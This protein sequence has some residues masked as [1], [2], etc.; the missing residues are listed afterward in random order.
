MK[1]TTKKPRENIANLA[2]ILGYQVLKFDPAGESNLVR[3]LLGRNYPRFHLYLKTGANDLVF[4]L[5]LDQ[6][7]PSYGR[8]T[9]H[10]GEYDGELVEGERQRIEQILAK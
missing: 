9:S 7:K 1:F 8:E 2:R 10:S 4:N 5:H 6:K 3:P